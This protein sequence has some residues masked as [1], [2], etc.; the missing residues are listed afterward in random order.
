MK[1]LLA[2]KLA[3]G[4]TPPQPAASPTKRKKR[5]AGSK[6]PSKRGGPVPIPVEF[7]SNETRDDQLLRRAFT[8]R[9]DAPAVESY[10]DNG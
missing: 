6:K 10:L 4:T 1:K 3:G 5:P 9:D 2:D 8:L 7:G